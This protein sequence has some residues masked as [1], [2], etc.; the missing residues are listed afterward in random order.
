M[1][2][3]PLEDPNV[4]LDAYIISPTPLEAVQHWKGQESEDDFEKHHVIFQN[5]DYVGRMM[6]MIVS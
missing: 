5:G 2:K 3:L 1:K 4:V 6:K